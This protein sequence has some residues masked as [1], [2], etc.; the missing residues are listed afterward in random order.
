MIYVIYSFVYV[1]ICMSHCACLSHIYIQSCSYLNLM[2]P[3]LL[4]LYVEKRNLIEKVTQGLAE[5]SPSAFS[6]AGPDCLRSCR[7][8]SQGAKAKEA[9]GGVRS[10]MVELSIRQQEVRYCHHT[11]WGGSNLQ[12]CHVKHLHPS[13]K[14]VAGWTI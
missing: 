14:Q 1:H 9:G 5:K 3:Y 8:V 11:I 13:Y 12:T 7:L 4:L 2:N 10:N 6:F